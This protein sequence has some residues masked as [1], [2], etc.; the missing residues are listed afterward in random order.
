MMQPEDVAEAVMFAINLPARAVIEEIVMQAEIAFRDC[1]RVRTA[2]R[3][4]RSG[5][6]GPRV[7][8]LQE[9]LGKES[10]E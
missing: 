4:R 6:H 8:T 5:N 3:F 7:R 2:D 1:C 10:V 9:T